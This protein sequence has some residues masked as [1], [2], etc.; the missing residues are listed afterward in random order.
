MTTYPLFIQENN[1]KVTTMLNE[2]IKPALT[3]IAILTAFFC[4]IVYGYG[5]AL[6]TYRRRYVRKT[7]NCRYLQEEYRHVIEQMTAPPLEAEAWID[8]IEERITHE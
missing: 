4:G 3:T 2:T 7:E 6:L 1:Q 8:R 5:A